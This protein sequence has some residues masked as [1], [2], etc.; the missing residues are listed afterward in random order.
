MVTGAAAVVD[1]AVRSAAVW[2]PDWPILAWK[3][4]MSDPVAVVHANRVVACSPQARRAG[5][6][7]G[8]RRRESQRRCPSL[9]VLEQDLQ[10]EARAFEPVATA[11]DDLTPRVEIVRPGLIVFSTR[12]PSRYFGGDQAMAQRC[13]ALVAEVLAG[14]GGAMV[15]VADGAF[16]ASLAARR[17]SEAD[18]VV[19]DPGE[20]AAF[21]SPFSVQ[22]LDRPELTSVLMRLGLNTLGLF[23]ALDRADVV[24]RFGAEG[25]V[26]HRL[27]SGL[28]ER[29]PA[30][31]D[32]P[33]DMEVVTELDP[34]IERVDQAA[35]VGKTLA[36]EFLDRLDQRGAT[37]AGVVIT[38]E[39]EHG[40]DLVRC[41]R[42]E[43]TLTAAVVAD[44]VRWQLD[45]WLN[46][47][48]T[49]R[50]SGGLTR[51]S[52]RPDAV[53]AATGRQLGFWGGQTEAAARAARVVARVQGLLGPD[54]VSAPERMGGRSP[55]EQI[56][57][58]QA[59]T[60]DLDRS[61]IDTTAVAGPWPGA[62]PG[63][64]PVRMAQPPR[65]VQVFDAEGRPVTVDGRAQISAPPRRVVFDDRSE[66]EVCQWAGPWPLDERW[67]DPDR[68]RRRARFQI[69]GDAGSAWL[70]TVEGGQWW[71][72]ATY[73]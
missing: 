43:G 50:P 53:I 71:L 60:V 28:D 48:S 6:E 45:G 33:E 10:L 51:L 36:D 40:E 73:D 69:V 27:A 37:C 32:P 39:T 57:L 24:G 31:S 42:H 30:M 52:V 2:C 17:S 56:R 14:N 4:E 68:H 63:P 72:E 15:G 11:L 58:V 20:S 54:A 46:G 22:V 61:H 64:A 44:R 8:L 21:L 70:V 29:P 3:R 13:V 18:M 34:P 16:A 19:V 55:S 67:W 62:L 65:P 47:S 5:V 23:A 26:A 35:F 7:R 25:L 66:H 38:A 59:D 41:W 12:G 1:E 9:E 49:A